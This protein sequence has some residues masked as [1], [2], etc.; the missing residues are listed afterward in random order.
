[1]T[2]PIQVEIVGW[3]SQLGR[4]LCRTLSER[5]SLQV[6][7]LFPDEPKIV[8]AGIRVVDRIYEDDMLSTSA[9]DQVE[10]AI[11]IPTVPSFN[12]WNCIA[13]RPD[14]DLDRAVHRIA[15]DVRLRANLFMRRRRGVMVFLPSQIVS[16]QQS[17]QAGDSNFRLS[18]IDRGMHAL[19]KVVAIE[20]AGKGVRSFTISFGGSR[21]PSDV[22]GFAV[23]LEGLLGSAAS[24]STGAL[25]EVQS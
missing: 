20:Y 18:I 3:G 5:T 12:E 4:E 15:R 22:P 24:Y 1:M 2:T 7:R 21:T 23:L 17:A 10:L 25:I 8:G 13:G 9:N 19:S 6:C 16:E 11:F 14:R